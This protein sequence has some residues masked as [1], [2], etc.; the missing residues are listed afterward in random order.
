[1]HSKGKRSVF[2]HHLDLPS[3]E[4]DFMDVDPPFLQSDFGDH[5][6][7]AMY[8]EPTFDRGWVDESQTSSFSLQL[9]KTEDVVP[10]ATPKGADPGTAH[11]SDRGYFA[12]N[13]VPNMMHNTPPLEP[14][15]FVA[16]CDSEA[17]DYYP[18]ALLP[19][20]RHMLDQSNPITPTYGSQSQAIGSATYQSSLRDD[21]CVRDHIFYKAAPKEDCL[22]HC[23]IEGCT[24][25][26]EKLKCNY[27][28]VHNITI[29]C[30]I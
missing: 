28:Y 1:M 4:Y 30:G 20:R 15:N 27:E 24:H 14:I 8:D 25:T 12:M 18:S 23:P 21:R 19:S 9:P 10:G 7:A 5:A 3:S 6:N 29:I 16:S 22:Y 26:A 13:S 17:L 11:K 2:S